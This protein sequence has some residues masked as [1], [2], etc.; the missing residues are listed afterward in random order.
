MKKGIKAARIEK[1]N[2][3]YI[4]NRYDPVDPDITKVYD[5]IIYN[6]L[7]AW[8]IQYFLQHLS[9]WEQS[10]SV[11]YKTQKKYSTV[12]IK[13]E[14]FDTAKHSTVTLKLYP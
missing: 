5:I 6:V 9:V 4:I 1:Q 2:A 13:T 3:N 10:I 12:R 8:T 7:V 11:S 14:I